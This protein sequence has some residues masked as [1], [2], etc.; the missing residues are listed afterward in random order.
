MT[1]THTHTLQPE[2]AI[3]ALCT[4]V[5]LGRATDCWTEWLGPPPGWAIKL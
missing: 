5:L 2:Q 1:Q 3:E 4:L